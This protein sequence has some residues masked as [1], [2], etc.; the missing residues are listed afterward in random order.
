M[1]SSS[2]F[3]PDIR[4]AQL[5]HTPADADQILPG[6]IGCVQFRGGVL[7][8]CGHPLLEEGLVWGGDGEGRVCRRRGH[9]VE[10][11]ARAPS[12]GFCSNRQRRSFDGW[13]RSWRMH[14][15]YRN[16][17]RNNSLYRGRS[18]K[19]ADVHINPLSNDRATAETWWGTRGCV[20]YLPVKGKTCLIKWNKTARQ[21]KLANNVRDDL[22]AV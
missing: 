4:L 17:T 12:L 21:S 8:R 16:N 20:D 18:L 14:Q 11:D 5:A 15:D 13:R 3:Q 2:A 10:E 22:E 1:K 6:T 19:S 9:L 7:D